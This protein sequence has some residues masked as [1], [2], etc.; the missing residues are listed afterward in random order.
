VEKTLN[1]HQSPTK[2]IW[3]GRTKHVF[4]FLA[5]AELSFDRSQQNPIGCDR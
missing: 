5:G 3:T 2:T 4:D 1:R